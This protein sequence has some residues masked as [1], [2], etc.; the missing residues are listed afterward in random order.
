M[1]F[2]TRQRERSG[3]FFADSMGHEYIALELWAEDYRAA[4]ELG[5][6]AMR[7]FAESGEHGFASTASGRLAQAYYALDRLEEAEAAAARADVDALQDVLRMA[8][9]HRRKQI[10]SL[11]R[12]ART[13]YTAE[14]L[15]RALAQAEIDRTARPEAVPPEQFLRLANAAAAG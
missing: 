15:T 1:E 3:Q 6:R 2:R 8:F 4:V 13:P 14:Q 12:R 11:A 7:A 10:R 5:E 9:C